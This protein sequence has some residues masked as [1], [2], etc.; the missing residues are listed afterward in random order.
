MLN[1]H[2]SLQSG[3]TYSSTNIIVEPKTIYAQSDNSGSV[4]YRINTS[5]GYGYLSPSFSSNPAVGDS[6][7]AFTSTH[8]LNYISIPLALKYNITKDKFSFNA[9][10]GLS[11]NILTQGKIETL[12]EKGVNN[13]TEVVNN[14]QGF[15][16]NR[17]EIF[18]PLLLLCLRYGL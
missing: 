6:L 11:I 7:Y 8:T 16:F 1:K 14:L 10:T 9:M 15:L 2:W 5:S 4:K 12:V 18:I 13:E 3:L 17:L